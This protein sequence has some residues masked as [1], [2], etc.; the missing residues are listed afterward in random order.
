MYRLNYDLELLRSRDDWNQKI[1][2]AIRDAHVF[3]LFWSKA[4]AASKAVEQEWR[5]AF[6]LKR[7]GFICPVHWETDQLSPPPPPELATI[8]FQRIQIPPRVQKAASDGG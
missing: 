6:S 4:A 3:Q 1:K 8:N 7:R 2:M 5:Y